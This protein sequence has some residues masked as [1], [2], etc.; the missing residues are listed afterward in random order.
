MP[1]TPIAHVVEHPTALELCDTYLQLQLR[2]RR[3]DEAAPTTIGP[4]ITLSHQVG[5]E[6]H[7]IAHQVAGLLQAGAPKGAIPWTV[8]DR[9]L[10]E[11]M[12]E[13]HHLPRFLADFI[14]EDRRSMIQ[15]TIDE[16]LGSRIPSWDV[17]PK[18]AETVLH[19]AHA[20][21]AILV[22]RGA[23]VIA[24]DLPHMLHVRL[25]T[26]LDHRVAHLQEAEHLTAAEAADRIHREDKAAG[27]YIKTHFHVSVEND[28]LYH[29]TLNLDR[30]TSSQA[31]H[32]IAEAARQVFTPRPL[33]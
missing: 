33:G 12:L 11:I 5:S 19:L 4:A 8:F 25:L 18:I 27:R 32:L 20:G 22:G 26:S 16:L 13:E 15:D 29:L 24:A 21:H 23:N 9:N 28:A 1:D 31:A 3:E 10:V 14:A 6:D 7:E 2:K 17:V 30:L